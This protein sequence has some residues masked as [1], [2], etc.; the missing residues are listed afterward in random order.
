[1]TQVRRRALEA[2]TA[3]TEDGAYANLALK[4]AARGL[5][6][7]DA[8]FLFALVYGVLDHLLY[9]DY[10]LKAF[11]KPHKNKTVRAILRLGAGELLYL[12]TPAH[13]AI[14][15]AVNLTKAVGKSALSSYVN[16][17]LRSLDRGREN[18]PSLPEESSLRMSIQYSFP[19][20]L[21]EQWIGDYGQA[22]TE[23]LLS[24]AP[25]GLCL[26]PQYPKT[27]ADLEKELPCPLERGLWD[28]NALYPTE[29]LHP[30]GL[31]AF[32]EGRMT[33]QG[34]GAMLICRSLG[35]M[36][37]K[38]VLD[39]CAAP[40]GKSAYLYSL[41]EGDIHL[42][43]LEKHPHRA[44]LM[45]KT[46]DRLSVKGNIRVQDASEPCADF[47]N[48]FDAVLLDVPCSGL[49]L[50]MEKPDVRYAKTGD[51]IAALAAL[52]K[53]ILS[54]ACAWV[55]PGGLLLYATCTISRAENE[56]QIAAFLKEHPDF[57]LESLPLP[58][59]NQGMV[60]LFPHIHKTDG[61]FMAG[62]RRCI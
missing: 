5:S 53:K 15:Q 14:S 13:A 24:A 21:V 62:M 30:A 40:G 2:L 9:I 50:L 26:R 17:V 29:S 6:P 16:G 42:T 27:A 59:E 61:F 35:D 44:E 3:I 31:P 47:E 33:V 10:I 20:W 56:D 23:A 11:T 38:R 32:T 49:G 55:R 18:L 41:A 60:Q 1:M 45:E 54:N 43:C 37:G 25:A 52:Q 46:F 22:F 28:E 8:R 4:E 57:T 7:E 39:A 48:A 51:D 19:L 12:R 58:L 36:K 34:E